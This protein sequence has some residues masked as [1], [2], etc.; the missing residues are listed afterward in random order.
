ML[1]ARRVFHVVG[2]ILSWMFWCFGLWSQVAFVS[3]Y[4]NSLWPKLRPPTPSTSDR[5]VLSLPQ[6]KQGLPWSVSTS[7]RP[8]S[9]ECENRWMSLHGFINNLGM[10]AQL[11]LHVWYVCICYIVLQY[12]K[13]ST[14]VFYTVPRSGSSKWVR[15]PKVNFHMILKE[16]QGTWRSYVQRCLWNPCFWIDKGMTRGPTVTP[17][18]LF[19]EIRLDDAKCIYAYSYITCIYLDILI[20]YIL[21]FIVCTAL[22]VWYIYMSIYCIVVHGPFPH[23]PS[24]ML[25]HGMAP[26]QNHCQQHHHY[27]EKRATLSIP[28]N[29]SWV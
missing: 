21:I 23:V 27:Q 29:Q 3:S 22:L 2:W 15:F 4:I 13:S 17:P 18:R 26:I 8:G 25:P 28:Q 11:V 20:I 12:V 7:S 5:G 1:G 10:C 16:I 24:H 14:C 9:W 6:D 19:E